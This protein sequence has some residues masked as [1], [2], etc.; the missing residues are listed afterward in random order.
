MKRNRLPAL[1]LTLLLLLNLAVPALAVDPGFAPDAAVTRGELA[2]ALYDREGRPAAGAAR[3]ADAQ[4]KWYAPAAAW[5]GANG[6][7]RGGADGRF[8]GGREITRAELAG[9]L[10]RY[11]GYK[12]MPV[13][14]AQDTNILSY[15][16][17]FDTPSW[18]ME[19]FQWT[20][21]YGVLAEKRTGGRY[22]LAAEDIVTRAEL[23]Q[24]LDRMERLGDPLSLWTDGAPAK[25]ALAE[26]MDAVTDE[27]GPDFIPVKDRIAVF[28]MDG[29]ILNETDPNYYDYT[30]LLY[31]V[32]EDPDYKDKASAF[33]REVAEKI[34]VMN[35]TG[36]SAKGLD[37]DHGKAVASAFAGMSVDE[38]GAYIRAFLERPMPGYANMTRREGFYRPM[39]QVIDY[40][41][42]NDFT[43]YIVSGTDRFI[44]RNIV[45]GV[46]DIPA[47]QV[48]GSD[49][50][51]VAT[52]QG[53][54]DAFGYVFGR[55]DDVVLGG[56]FIIKNLKMNKVGVIVQEIGQQPV[57]SF[58]NSS[59]DAS[60]A[61][62]TIYNNPHRS[63]AFMLC[64]D[65]LARENGNLK[66]AES[67]RQ[68]CE[69][70][71]W[72]AVSMRDDWTTIYGEGVTRK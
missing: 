60:M 71:G 12:G 46:L 19:G 57:L 32:T 38:F 63:A 55:E 28:D 36:V 33:E 30:L 18:A 44:A 70:Y 34:R 1:L 45:S 40:L 7:Y 72:T 8:D 25:A 13:S 59:G 3:F 48:I 53:D 5:C 64:C 61:N 2:Q 14:A 15:D 37:I 56:D 66:K 42:A 65:D 16:D 10:Y 52:H 49:E 68:S 35:E 6:I 54:A 4:G 51:V 50:T 67:M 47:S 31:R 62:Y 29:T 43:V 23:A 26:Y 21:A 27:N 11:A 39:L 58:G 20:C 22:E 24:A 41:Q 69:E 17:A 9:V